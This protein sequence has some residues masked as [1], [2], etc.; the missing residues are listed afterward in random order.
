MATVVTNVG[1][2]NITAG[3][4]RTGTEPTYVGWGTG[5]GTAAA[6][7]TVLFT[8][9]SAGSPAYARIAGTSSQVTTT[10]T[11]D[12][13][14]LVATLTANAAKTITNAGCF[15]ALTVGNLF[16][17]GD[18]AGVALNANDSIQFTIQVQLT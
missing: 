2:A 5:A 18:F 14:Q 11:N 12:T 16:V 7:D 1:K 9:D 6:T 4:K 8:E 3:I 15:D 13:Y 17:H 10:T